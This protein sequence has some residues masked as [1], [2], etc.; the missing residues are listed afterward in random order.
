MPLVTTQLGGL[1]C[2]VFQHGDGPPRLA[3]VLCHGFGAPGEDLVPLGGEL[4]HGRPELEDV[5]FVFP[6]A[7]LSLSGVIPGWDAARAWWM[8]DLDRLMSAQMGLGSPSKMAEAYRAEVPEGLAP[9]RRHMM[10]LV[11]ELSRASGLPNSK[12][13]L[14][15]FSQG[16]MLAVDVS[17]RLEEAPAALVILSGT[18]IAEPE[19]K[20]RAPVRK[21]LRVFQSH[22]RRDP[23]LP[24]DNAERLRNLLAEAGLEV[25]FLPF[26]GEH[27]IPGE[28]L[29][30]VA[31][32]LSDRLKA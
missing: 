11:D 19:W 26:D 24:F 23:I 21:G 3:V 22:G 20:A 31:D 17:L 13:V 10:A 18:L 8:L 15:G 29:G 12:I 28:A 16:A 14:G 1:A 6:A 4:V 7:P 25:E 27:T 30:R 5:R 2:R 32:L 9:A